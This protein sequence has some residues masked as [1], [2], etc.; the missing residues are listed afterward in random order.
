MF[1]STTEIFVFPEFSS[2]IFELRFATV[3]QNCSRIVRCREKLI[4]QRSQHC[5]VPPRIVSVLH[6]CAPSNPLL[7]PSGN[8]SAIEAVNEH[9]GTF[10]QQSIIKNE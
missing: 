8:S 6:E 1:R 4:S 2:S 10:A 9:E 3:E 5:Y 7:I